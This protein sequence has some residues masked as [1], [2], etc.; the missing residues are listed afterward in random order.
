MKRLLSSSLLLVPFLVAPALAKELSVETAPAELSLTDR[1]NPPPVRPSNRVDDLATT[2]PEGFPA[3]AEGVTGIAY[4][5]TQ[6]IGTSVAIAVG[7]TG[8][9]PDR[10]LLDLNGD[11]TFGADEVLSPTFGGRGDSIG[12]TLRDQALELGGRSVKVLLSAYRR[13]AGGTW[14][15]SVT[16]AWYRTGTV[17]LGDQELVLDMVDGDLDGE[18]GSEKDRWMVREAG[19]VRRPASVYQLQP[20]GGGAFVAGHRFSLQSLDGDNAKLTATAAEGPDP[21]DEAADRVRAEHTW[22]ERFDAERELFIEQRGVDTTRPRAEGTIDWKYVTFE[23]AM[24]LGKEAEKPVF[25]DVLAFWCVWCYRMDYYT[26]VDAEVT[27]L[28]TEDFIPVKILQEQDRVGD[29]AKVMA[30]LEMRGI[31]AMGV[32]G[33]DGALVHK[34]SGWK[35]PV[36]FIAELEQAKAAVGGSAEASE[37]GE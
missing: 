1:S 10:L 13:G 18:Y 9:A 22:F 11:G 21:A 29:Y 14:K 2:A 26:Y 5:H 23:E 27:R 20:F 17:K 24:R 36:D 8:G 35:K 7:H 30:Q 12:T 4:G 33:P 25:I 32:W 15:V 37:S 19:P 6:L 16:P 34:I 28:L 3:L 31:P